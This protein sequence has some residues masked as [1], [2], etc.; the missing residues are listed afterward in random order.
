MV[1][2]LHR[3]YML[4]NIIDSLQAKAAPY[5]KMLRIKHQTIG[6]IIFILG[7]LDANYF[8]TPQ[9][10][11]AFAGLAF[12]SMAGFMI[13][14]YYDAHDTDKFSYR[15]RAAIENVVSAKVVLI[16]W[17]IFNLLSLLLLASIGLLTQGVVFFIVNT[18]YSAPPLR[19]KARVFWDLAI[20]LV[21][22]GVGYSIGS[23]LAGDG[24]ISAIFSLQFLAV[25]LFLGAGEFI[26]LIM[27]CEADKKAGLKNTGAVLGYTWLIR[28]SKVT[29][30]LSAA[31]FAI[32]CYL[33]ESWWYYPL[34]IALPYFG[35]AVGRLREAIDAKKDL[36]SLLNM[37]YTRAMTTMVLISTYLVFVFIYGF[38]KYHR[39]F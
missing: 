32:L 1:K 5:I 28:I 13:N 23:V 6:V 9:I 26:L 36:K 4:S 33:Q 16:I 37:S 19:F 38:A 17:L 39:I 24:T 11:I 29:L 3:T 21:Q 30:L 22:V 34:I 2:L 15:K 31:T 14:D 10:F 20:T 27:D 18:T 12:S 7:L 35:Y 25:I 8:Q